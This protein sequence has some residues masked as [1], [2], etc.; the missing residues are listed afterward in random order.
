MATGFAVDALVR[1][2]GASNCN[3]AVCCLRFI[4]FCGMVFGENY[5]RYCIFTEL[6]DVPMFVTVTTLIVGAGVEVFAKFV[7]FVENH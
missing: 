2:V 6:R 1:L 4:F 5:K 3:P 7:Y